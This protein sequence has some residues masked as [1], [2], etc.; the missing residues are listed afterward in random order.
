MYNL[1]NRYVTRVNAKIS[2]LRQMQNIYLTPHLQNYLYSLPRDIYSKN[3][4]YPLTMTSSNTLAV[5][6]I[7]SPHPSAQSPRTT[8]NPSPRPSRK[9]SRV[10]INKDFMKKDVDIEDEAEVLNFCVTF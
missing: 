5:T 1:K 8:P 2:S 6:P 4:N 9:S 10:V 7:P 3:P